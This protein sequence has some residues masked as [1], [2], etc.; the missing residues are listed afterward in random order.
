MH[1][2]VIAVSKSWIK[3]QEDISSFSHS[4][5]AY[6]IRVFIITG[7]F[8]SAFIL[9]LH[10]SDIKTHMQSVATYLQC[11]AKNTQQLQNSDNTSYLVSFKTKALIFTL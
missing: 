6:T 4:T 8:L 7:I 3:Y 9:Q 11:K 10:N 5:A 1:K 2:L